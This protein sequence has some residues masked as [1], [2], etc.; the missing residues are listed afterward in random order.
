MSN[1]K[2]SF[3]G[4]KKTIDSFFLIFGDPKAQPCRDIVVAYGSL[5]IH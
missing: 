1:A 5:V 2:L 3:A 4:E